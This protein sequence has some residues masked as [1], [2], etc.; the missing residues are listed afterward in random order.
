[1]NAA[2]PIHTDE[3]PTAYADRVGVWYASRTSD[4]HKSEHGQ[5]LTPKAVARF[6]AGLFDGIDSV[7]RILDPGAGSGIL[8]CAACEAL[9]TVRGLQ[10]IEL[11]AYEAEAGLSALLDD[12]LK[13][14]RQWLHAR[15]VEFSFE[16]RCDDFILSKAACIKTRQHTLFTKGGETFDFIISNPPYFKIPKADPRA[17]AAA[18]V[19]HGQPNIY[20]LFMAVSAYLLKPGGQLVFITPRS[21][22]AGPYFHRF[23]EC[24]FE[25][26]RPVAVHLF[27]SRTEAFDRDAVLQEH[28]ILKGI[29]DDGWSDK[30]GHHAVEVSFSAGARDLDTPCR[31]KVPMSEVVDMG[32]HN[33]FLHIPVSDEAQAIIHLVNS[34]RGNLRAYGLE[35]STGPVVPFRAT[36]F[37]ASASSSTTVP[38]LWMQNVKAMSTTWPVPTRKQQYIVSADE[39]RAL[40][41]PN[42]NYVLLRRF[43]AKEERRRLTAAPYLASALK[44]FE[45]IGL[46][47]HLNYIH[48]PKGALTKAEAYGIAALLN[49]KLL[50]VYFRSFNGNT[51]VSATE[52]RS[53][54]LPPLE[55]IR[56][57]GEEVAGMDFVTEALDAWLTNMLLQ[58]EGH[59]SNITLFPNRQVVFRTS[60]PL[61]PRMIHY[62]GDRFIGPR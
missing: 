37:I 48:R 1:M 42:H 47:N 62:N 51:Q 33:K 27:G 43:S 56:K 50:D 4:T 31:R 24:F 32:S 8:S 41:L 2:L 26:V 7:A 49:C 16:V 18:H 23:R 15:G 34:W 6:M 29:R 9:A 45:L 38:L 28:V 10:R 25:I 30:A 52:L 58:L 13:N 17:I 59:K 40:L 61:V 11:V 60:I 12:V 3:S 35:I 22:A 46:E 53:I 55:V 39:S 54:P 57:V 44:G 5:Y 20:A 14:L 36:Q 21:F 19:V